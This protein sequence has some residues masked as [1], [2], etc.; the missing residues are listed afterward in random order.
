MKNLTGISK[1]S[2]VS[3]FSFKRKANASTDLEIFLLAK[4]QYSLCGN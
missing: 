1:S 2:W 4:K 3:S